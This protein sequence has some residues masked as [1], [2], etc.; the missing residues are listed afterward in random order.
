MQAHLRAVLDKCGIGSRRELV[1]TLL[2]Q[3]G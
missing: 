3:S 1:A 2:G